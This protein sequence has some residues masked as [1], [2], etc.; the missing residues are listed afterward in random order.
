M[1]AATP[2]ME[3]KLE[4][5]LENLSKKLSESHSKSLKLTVS[6]FNPTWP[7]PDIYDKWV[8]GIKQVPPAEGQDENYINK[9]T[10]TLRNRM[11]VIA[12]EVTLV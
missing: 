7:S 10:A 8:F 4:K 9:I 11:A 5:A 3:S 1:K 12:V 2:E 6:F